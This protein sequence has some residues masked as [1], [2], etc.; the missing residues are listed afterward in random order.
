MVG[1]CSRQFNI[2]GLNATNSLS[3][4]DMD[5]SSVASEKDNANVFLA[6]IQTIL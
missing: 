4:I 3:M 2:Y 5:G 6:N 1:D